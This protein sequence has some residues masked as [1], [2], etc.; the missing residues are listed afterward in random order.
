MRRVIATITVEKLSYTWQDPT[1]IWFFWTRLESMLFSKIQ[2]NKAD[3]QDPVLQE[4][5]KLL[6]YDKNGGWALF[7]KGSS[8]VLNGHSSTVLPSLSEYDDWKEHVPQRGFEGAF[9]DHHDGLHGAAHTC[10]RFEFSTTAGRIPDDMRCP[11][12][13]RLMEKYMTFVC[14]HDENA[15]SALY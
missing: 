15:I 12:C 10:C 4:I 2:L 13:H 1:M 14:C 6:S 8:M 5:K 11:E 7:S 3:V 9:K